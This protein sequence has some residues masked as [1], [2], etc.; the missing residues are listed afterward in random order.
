MTKPDEYKTSVICLTFGSNLAATGVFF[1]H[2]CIWHLILNVN[3]H[4]LWL[5]NSDYAYIPIYFA[6]KGMGFWPR[7][8]IQGQLLS[9]LFD[10]QTKLKT[11][12]MQR[13]HLVDSYT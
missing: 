2:L 11:K 9:F 4:C 5:F 12:V 1:N 13:R 3:T 8:Q 10:I 6:L 7:P